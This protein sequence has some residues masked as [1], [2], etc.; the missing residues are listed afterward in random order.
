MAAVIE[1]LDDPL[2]EELAEVLLLCS[3]SKPEGCLGCQH[4]IACMRWWDNKVC[5]HGE[6]GLLE[7]NML[8]EYTFEFSKIQNGTNGHGRYLLI[9]STGEYQYA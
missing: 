6:Q 9:P 4:F 5:T 3:L 1:P 8:K 7:L 2:F